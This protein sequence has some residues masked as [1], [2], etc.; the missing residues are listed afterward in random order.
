MRMPMLQTWQNPDDPFCN[1]QAG[2]GEGVAHS[3]VIQPE[4][5]LGA[6]PGAAPGAPLLSHDQPDASN[7]RCTAMAVQ[8]PGLAASATGGTSSAPARSK[9]L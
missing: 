6:A 7:S 9:H 8:T 2:T 5:P 3:P 1:L 4:N